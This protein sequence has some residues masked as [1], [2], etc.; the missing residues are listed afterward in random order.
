M[1]IGPSMPQAFSADLS[2][3][4]SLSRLY[5]AVV[6]MVLLPKPARSYTKVRA[7]A[8][9]IFG[10]I[11]AHTPDSFPNPASNTT[12]T[13]P[14]PSSST[15]IRLRPIVRTDVVHGCAYKGWA[16]IQLI[17][18]ARTR[19]RI[20]ERNH[21]PGSFGRLLVLLASQ[22]RHQSQRLG[23]VD[24]ETRASRGDA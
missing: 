3:A 7:P 22:W 20:R 18:P 24:H 9:R 17:K 15:Q 21:P 8:A 2:M 14:V 10:V 5:G 4:T 23:C 12:V 1:I 16:N 19:D 13:L 6:S 11:F